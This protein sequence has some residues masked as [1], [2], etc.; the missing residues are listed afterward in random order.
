MDNYDNREAL[1]RK[2]YKISMED[3]INL[4][5][6]KGYKIQAEFLKSSSVSCFIVS[7]H[8]TM[9]IAILCS[10]KNIIHWQES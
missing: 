9:G 2:S 7:N 5:E 1:L 4:L 3:G 6:Q 10:S 8:P